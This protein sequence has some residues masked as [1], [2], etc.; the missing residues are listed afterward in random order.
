MFRDIAESGDKTNPFMYL[1]NAL[2]LVPLSHCKAWFHDSGY[3]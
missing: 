2:E 1:Y 3:L